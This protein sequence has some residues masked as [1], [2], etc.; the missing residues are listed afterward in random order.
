MVNSKPDELP[1]SGLIGAGQRVWCFQ[2]WQTSDHKH[3]W[4]K[5]KQHRSHQVVCHSYE[6]L[7]C[8]DHG[9]TKLIAATFCP[10]VLRTAPVDLTLPTS[11]PCIY[12]SGDVKS[13]PQK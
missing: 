8:P 4:A 1:L 7:D 10:S 2:S 3:V 9:C 5:L 11:N 6:Q 13:G 12:C